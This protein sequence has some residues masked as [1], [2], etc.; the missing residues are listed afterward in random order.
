MLKRTLASIAAAF[1][2]VAAMAAP[3]AANSDHDHDHDGP[4]DCPHHAVCFW[5]EAHFEGDMSVRWNPGPH[6]DEAPGHRIGSVVNNLHE[7]VRLY[8]D[9]DCD[10]LTEVVHSHDWDKRVHA[11]S[12]R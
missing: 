9:D 3:A 10:H 6:C 7:K 5:E 1:L 2:I 12:W 8:K 4:H 11:H